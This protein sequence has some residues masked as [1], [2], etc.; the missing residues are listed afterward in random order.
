MP[1][2]TEMKNP[3][4]ILNKLSTK[5]MTKAEIKKAL[6]IEYSRASESILVLERDGYLITLDTISSER[7]KDTKLYGLT[8]KGTITYLSSISIINQNESK[9]NTE[10]ELN[11]PNKIIHK[12]SKIS[13]LR[14]YETIEEYNQR[15]EKEKEK[16]HKELEKIANFL[17]TYGKQL[18]YPLFS[19]IQWLKEKYGYDIFETLIREAKI[20]ID[21]KPFPSSGML[22]I[23]NAQK[24]VKDLRNRKWA[25]QRDP[26]LKKI[27]QNR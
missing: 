26:E 14:K 15:K 2:I 10:P 19:E 18:H 12:P 4:K 22:N 7:G 13:P 3:Y 21:L 16:Y 17:E 8:F 11:K 24:K 1:S 27:G 25:L 9:N 20:I 23:N 5:P 6:R